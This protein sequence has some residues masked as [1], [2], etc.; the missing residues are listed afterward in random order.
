MVQISLPENSKTKKGKY[1]WEDGTEYEEEKPG[2]RITKEMLNGSAEDGDKMH[3]SSRGL[4]DGEEFEGG[5]GEDENLVLGS[6]SMIDGFESGLIG[7]SKGD[8]KSLDLRFPE[9]YRNDELSDK[10]VKFEIKVLSVKEANLPELDGDF[11]K[12]FDVE[13][14]KLESFLEKIKGKLEKECETMIDRKLNE[15]IIN[16]L[17]ELNQ[18]DVPS[19]LK[20]EE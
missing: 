6:Q 15:E 9:N 16:T 13:D 20:M 18:F 4:I 17:L 3:I 1:F 10:A 5:V 14:G 8:E 19:S 11:M 12:K 2:I 7:S